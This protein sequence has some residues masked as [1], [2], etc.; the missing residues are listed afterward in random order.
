MCSGAN[1][2]QTWRDNCTRFWFFDCPYSVS[3]KPW[4]QVDSLSPPLSGQLFSPDHSGN[5]Q[6]KMEARLAGHVD[7]H[8]IITT[9][10]EVIFFCLPSHAQPITL[11]FWTFPIS[12]FIDFAIMRTISSPLL[13]GLMEN[14]PSRSAIS[15]FFRN[16]SYIIFIF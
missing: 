3:E 4:T 14:L 11:S 2:R 5:Y 6:M 1:A 8:C 16:F 13:C 12:N 7:D 10:P 9:W 15:R